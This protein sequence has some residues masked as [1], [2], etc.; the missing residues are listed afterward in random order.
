MA[1]CALWL[2]TTTRTAP[3]DLLNGP[4]RRSSQFWTDKILT[5]DGANTHTSFAVRS[6]SE[7]GSRSNANL[8]PIKVSIDVGGSEMLMRRTMML[9][10]ASRA[11]Q[12][13]LLGTIS[14]TSDRI[15]RTIDAKATA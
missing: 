9:T 1:A 5:A 3:L 11:A 10:P 2:R 15:A 7:I 4:V 12:R 8:S 14:A 6:R 13:T